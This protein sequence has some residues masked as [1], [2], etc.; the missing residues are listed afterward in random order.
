MYYEHFGLKHPPFK[1][2]PDTSLFYPGG[3]RG[4]VLEALSY[5]VRNGEG[6]VK[7]TG[8]VGSGKTMLCR[9]L[10][11][12][13]PANIEIVYLAN[14][15]LSP[16]NILHVVAFELKLPVSQDDNR[17]VVMQALQDYLLQRHAEN[18]QV[19][20]F[21]EEAQSMPLATLEEIR[22][23][24][25]LETNQ[26][27]LLQIV[28]FGQPE[29]DDM[30]A[31]PQ[32]RQL[33]ERI[34]YGFKLEPLK[35]QEIQE[36][37]NARLRSCGY[38]GRGLFTATAI[39]LLAR[40]SQG[41]LRRVNILADKALLAAY[42][43]NA[44]KV[45]RKQVRAAAR[46]SE[47][48]PGW[49]YYA[50]PV[51]AM[52]VVLSAAV[53]VGYQWLGDVYP[54]VA[55]SDDTT[56]VVEPLM[57]PDQLSPGPAAAHEPA[58]ERIKIELE[59][60]AAVFAEQPGI[61]WEALDIA[62]SS[63]SIISRTLPVAAPVAGPLMTLRYDGSDFGSVIR[64]LEEFGATNVLS[65]PQAMVLNN[66][67]AVLKAVTNVVYFEL[68]AD[69][70]STQTTALTTV[71]TETRTV[72][73]G[74][75]MAVTPQISP[76][77]TVTLNVRPTVSRISRFVPDPSIALIQA[78]FAQAG[79]VI[80]DVDIPPNEVP[81]MEVREMES[82]LRLYDGQ[83]AILGGLMQDE[84]LE[85]T[86]AIPGLSR[87]PFLGRAFRT[88]TRQYRKSELV[89]FLRPVIVRTPSLSADLE[90]Y[91]PVLERSVGTPRQSPGGSPR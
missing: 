3:N 80:G 85:G 40:Y 54:R 25:N 20:V 69:T 87:I 4:A 39:S 10:E 83:T 75:V 82:M 5:A 84:T 35:R 31:R 41:L 78:Q 32:I 76:D 37:L 91:R 70:T 26:D 73:E 50:W 1:I 19:V 34:T 59:P 45:G 16:D 24:S 58:A 62:G 9:M 15:R 55:D 7:V 29:L 23:L 12:E 67:T 43:D 42:A 66:Q 56:T 21:V 74:V 63:I 33:K 13:L 88:D 46:D 51:A 6:I 68:R 72:P 22:L 11:L 27:K 64:L 60:M 65:S 53:L 71:N 86:D 79:G 28:L 61:D 18:K 52:A 48:R 77:G 38:R 14:P 30:L 57:V 47:F 44:R 8:E 81:E 90:D 36:Y 2:T 89:V 49:P 17:I